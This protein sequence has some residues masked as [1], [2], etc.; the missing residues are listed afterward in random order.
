MS[1]NI[2]QAN[3]P[4]ASANVGDCLDTAASSPVLATCEAALLSSPSATIL[5]T[6]APKYLPIFS[7]CDFGA[8]R[9]VT[10]IFGLGEPG[11]EVIDFDRG[12]RAGVPDF[13]AGEAGGSMPLTS[14]AL[15]MLCDFDPCLRRAI[16]GFEEP[17]MSGSWSG[18]TTVVASSTRSF[19]MGA[20]FLKKERSSDD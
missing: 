20:E 3:N 12:L 16:L 15:D 8:A 2:F 9:Y 6:T 5:S 13:E 7:N 19:N 17:A 18:W 10:L 1:R 4:P 14:A 11:G